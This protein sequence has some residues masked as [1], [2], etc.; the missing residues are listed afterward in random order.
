MKWSTT[1]AMPLASATAIARCESPRTSMP[2]NVVGGLRPKRRL[3]RV[4]RL[5]FPGST[6]GRG[7]SSDSSGVSECLSGTN[8]WLVFDAVRLKGLRAACLA[9]PFGV[10]GPVPFEPRHLR[11]ALEREDVRRHAVE[12]PAVVGDHHRAA[13]E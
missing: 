6:S 2:A 1:R 11:V 7:R 4:S 13:G 3:Y 9:H 10:L 8:E 12:E 5:G